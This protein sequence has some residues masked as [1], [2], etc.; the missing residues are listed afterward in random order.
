LNQNLDGSK[1]GI[2]MGSKSDE[3]TV[4]E[5]INVLVELGIDY[6]VRILSA[7]RKPKA[8][9]DYL[10]SV[11]DRGIGVLI[12]AAGGAA[13][14]PGVMAAWTTIPVIGV[15][16]ASS[17]LNGLD[18]LM[19][20]AQMPPGIPVACVAI[21]SWGARNAAYLAASILGIKYPTIKEAYEK[22]RTKLQE[23]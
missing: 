14:L 3:L 16:L 4:Q 11:E 13:A 1:V 19:A 18:S 2:V 15:P 10:L 12:G 7:H 17:D 21:G 6:E 5:T 8:L 22:Y 23:A 20:I 9:M